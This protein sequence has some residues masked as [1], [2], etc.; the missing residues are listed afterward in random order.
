MTRFLVVLVLLA[1]TSAYAAKPKWRVTVGSST[2]NATGIIN[3]S[4]GVADLTLKCKGKNKPFKRGAVRIVCDDGLIDGARIIAPGLDC[5][6]LGSYVLGTGCDALFNVYF[7][8]EDADCTTAPS[9][10]IQRK[11]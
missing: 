3:E 5:I 9:L 11:R 7:D 8:A 1:A 2:C 4:E 6:Y 10:L